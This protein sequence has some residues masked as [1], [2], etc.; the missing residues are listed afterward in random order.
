MTAMDRVAFTFGDTKQAALYFDHVI[1][2][3]LMIEIISEHGIEVFRNAS[4]SS[5]IPWGEYV[6]LRDRFLRFAPSSLL[7]SKSTELWAELNVTILSS[8]S[9]LAAVSPELRDTPLGQLSRMAPAAPEVLRRLNT[10]SRD[11]GVFARH[12]GIRKPM[13]AGDGVLFT[14]TNEG[15]C[16]VLVKIS[17][18]N[19]V[20]TDSAT[21]E[22]IEDFRKDKGAQRKLRR[23]RLF[24]LENYEGRSASFI[25]DDLLQRIDEYEA[26]A[27]RWS[28]KLKAAA[29]GMV[30]KSKFLA[31]GAGCSLVSAL[32]G[33]PILSVVSVAVSAIAEFGNVAVELS[34]MKFAAN[35]AL[36][37][38]PVSYIVDAH[39][40]LED[41]I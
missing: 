10:L 35:E 7:S 30:F 15:A 36:G 41:K 1:P 21:L 3:F 9:S 19:L 16:D 20:D 27:R 13:F 5:E 34:R 2:L 25:E 23:L 12:L 40:S 17:G 29:A 8:L 37:D 14:Q 32:L 4:G 33:E 26:E 24:A 22:Q 18:L 28:F 11:M 6:L 39:K 31:G 38:N